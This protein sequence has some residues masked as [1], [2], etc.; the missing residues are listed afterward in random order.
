MKIVVA[1]LI[2]LSL[3]VPTAIAGQAPVAKKVTAHFKVYDAPR[4]TTY[5]YTTDCNPVGRYGWKCT[6]NWRAFGGRRTGFNVYTL[7]ARLTR[8]GG[9]LY[10]R[11]IEVSSGQ[12][13]HR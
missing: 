7:T 6:V 9:Y 2:A 13:I 4:S 10:G 1:T 8:T 12:S 3:F 11:I 5:G